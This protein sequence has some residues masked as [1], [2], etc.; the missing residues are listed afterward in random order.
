MKWKNGRA[1]INAIHMGIKEYNRKK[2]ASIVV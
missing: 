1:M 2:T